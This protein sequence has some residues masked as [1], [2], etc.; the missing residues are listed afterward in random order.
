MLDPNRKLSE[1]ETIALVHRVDEILGLRK[2]GTLTS[3]TSETA[4]L[5]LQPF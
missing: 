5:S 4:P 2:P 3:I 1:S